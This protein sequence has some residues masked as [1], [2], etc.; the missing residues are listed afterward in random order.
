MRRLLVWALPLALAACAEEP[1][2]DPSASTAAADSVAQAL[3]TYTPETFDSISWATDTAQ[4]NRG[5]VVW[6]FSCRKCHG[7]TAAGDGHWVM[8]GD[9]LHPPSFQTA[10]WRFATD[11]TGLVRYIYAGNASG[12][13]HWGVV[14]LKPRDIDAVAA[15]IQTMLVAPPAG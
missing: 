11:R 6:M 7:D 10:D 4:T 1:Q 15:Y 9:T 13:P 5:A 14:G 3:A 8:D 12:M 2:E